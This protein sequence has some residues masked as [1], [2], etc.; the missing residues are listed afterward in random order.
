MSA[1]SSLSEINNRGCDCLDQGDMENAMSNFRQGL[2]YVKA[3]LHETPKDNH[4]RA[5]RNIISM[6]V[7]ML[8]RTGADT[9]SETTNTFSK[10]NFIIHPHATRMINGYSFSDD[11][12][13]NSKIYTA[14][15]VFNLALTAHLQGL[16]LQSHRHIGQA[17]SLYHHTYQLIHTTVV[18]CYDGEATG[19]ASFDMLVLA[20]FN[21]MALVLFEFSDFAVSRVVFQ[22]LIRYAMSVS[23]SAEESS[24]L[25][26]KNEYIY[27]Q[28]N[29]FLLNATILG[30]NPPFA[31][32]AA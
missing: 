10:S 22:R 32:A 8:R 29:N 16:R 23:R 12:L 9:I 5:S 30:L 26:A 20:L 11:L 1:L 28:I 19:N 15:V 31:A 17:K 4:N 18:G 2:S 14:I 3:Y 7:D 27:H 24:L 25:E 13:E 6:P 21:N